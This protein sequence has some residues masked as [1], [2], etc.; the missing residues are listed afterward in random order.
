MNRLPRLAMRVGVPK[1]SREGERR[2]A[3]IPDAVGS[4]TGD[5]LEVAVES[6][7]GEGA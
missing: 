7:A 1:E 3:L 5:D 2:V 4:L 6:G